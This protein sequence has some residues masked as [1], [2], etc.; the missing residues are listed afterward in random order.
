MKR[1]LQ[2]VLALATTLLLTVGI[3]PPTPAVAATVKT[4]SVSI[5]GTAKVGSTLTAKTGKWK[6]SGVKLGYQWYRSGKAI[7][8][9]T[10]STYVVT[11]TDLGK[12]L[13]VKVAGSKKGYKAAKRTSAKT[14]KVGLGTITHSQVDILG[15]LAVGNTVRAMKTTWSPSGV[16]LS[17]QWF[18]DNDPIT[19]ATGPTYRLTAAD[20]GT[21]TGLIV[22]GRLAGYRDASPGL[23]AVDEVG[24]ATS[25]NGTLEVGVDVPPGTYQSAGGSG[26]YWERQSGP[27]KA[28]GAGPLGSG[29]TIVT[30]APTDRFFVPMGCGSW[31]TPST[32]PVTT[33]GDG[34]YLVGSQ[35]SPGRYQATHT[36]GTE[37]YW[38][39]RSGFGGTDGDI[40]AY[41]MYRKPLATSVVEV[42]IP[43]D[44]VGFVTDGCGQ[45][46]LVR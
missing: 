14:A 23:F 26:C 44:A 43:E 10:R 6:P 8:G 22:T 40:V 28:I 36:T 46:T 9:A 45:W 38:E 19:G 5:T 33:I 20:V 31:A 13:T 32:E 18:R 3:A 17:Y 12:Q 39:L 24:D 2:V 29:T 25:W 16:R 15:K 11:V 1:V 35:V 41:T 37:C 27:G 4:A 42:V 34:D 30:I 21:F 7:K